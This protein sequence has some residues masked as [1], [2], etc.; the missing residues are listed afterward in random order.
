MEQS[1][2]AKAQKLHL[3]ARELGQAGNYEA[4]VAKLEQ[5]I[6][7]QPD[8][9][10]PYYDLAFTY[11]LKGDFDKALQFYQK[12]DSLQPKG[13]FTTKT[14]LYSLQGEAA[15]K[16]P[17]G[18]YGYYLQIEW[19]E[20]ADK[21]FEIVKT[22]LANVPDFAPAWK[23]LALLTDNMETR[24]KYIDEG[25]SKDPDADTQGILLLNKAVIVNEA[26]NKEEALQ[27]LTTLIN[28]PYTTTGNVE[29]AKMVVTQIK[30]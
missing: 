16:F 21:K 3:E 4:S 26:G 11:L 25:L 19:T 22:I 27:I 28:D 18:L 14:A 17:K 9:A 29:L 1:I 12:T 13:F 15:G 30:G 7:I 5:A 24:E 2:D 20:D 8:W 23:E 6:A 10:Y